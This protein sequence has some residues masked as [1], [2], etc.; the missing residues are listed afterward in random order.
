MA[1][2]I[3]MILF[4]CLLEVSHSATKLSWQQL[5]LLRSLVIPESCVLSVK[6]SICVISLGNRRE[7]DPLEHLQ[8]DSYVK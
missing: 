4:P 3:T 1:Y 7:E 5:G 8:L 2:K 6:L